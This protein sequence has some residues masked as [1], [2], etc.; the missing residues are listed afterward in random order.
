MFSSHTRLAWVKKI[1]TALLA[2][3]VFL[4]PFYKLTRTTRILRRR[5]IPSLIALTFFIQPLAP[6]FAEETSGEASS[7]E[8]EASIEVSSEDD[9]TQLQAEAPASDTPELDADTDLSTP[10]SNQQSQA[11]PGSPASS[12]GTET[13][14]PTTSTVLTARSA[15]ASRLWCHP[16]EMV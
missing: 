9:A 14:L 2:V 4:S 6:A 10:E 11:A 8:A 13:S 12:G 7:A 5:I 15:T 1:A 3:I 16:A